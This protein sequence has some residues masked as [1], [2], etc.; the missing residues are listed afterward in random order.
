[1]R[2]TSSSATA[3]A[4]ALV[5]CLQPALADP[6]AVP[7]PALFSKSGSLTP[8]LLPRPAAAQGGVMAAGNGPQKPVGPPTPAAPTAG[9]PAPTPIVPANKPPAWTVAGPGGTMA[10][11]AN[12]RALV[13]RASGYLTSVQTVVGDFVQVAPDGSRSEGKFYL[14]KPGRVRFEYDPPNAVELIAD[15]ESV[16]VRDRKLLTQELYPLSQTPLR[17]LLADRVDLLKDTD[18]IGV[19]A[20][21]L[22]VSLLLE[23]RHVFGGTHR[24]MLM[25]GAQDY[26]LRQWTITDPQGYDTTVAIY[27]LDVNNKR[28]LNPE[29]FKINF[30]RMLP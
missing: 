8:P 11:D 27:N 24:V 20:D 5:L 12:Q 7:R 13:E 9:Q 15:G 14:Q 19:Y 28:Q 10:L 3:T 21:E 4:A 23:E 22:F 30:Q 2:R 6:I 16:A 29:L 17:F 18:L 25:F 1:M 26:R